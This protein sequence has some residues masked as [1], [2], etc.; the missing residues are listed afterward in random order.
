[1]RALSQYSYWGFID[2]LSNL[3]IVQT[4]DAISLSEGFF[5]VEENYIVDFLH[6]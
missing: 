5:F 4:Y 2:T 1:M 3:N 6:F